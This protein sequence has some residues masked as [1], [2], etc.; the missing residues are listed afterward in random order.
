MC[1]VKLL[2]PP[3]RLASHM[4]DDCVLATCKE[5]DIRAP[6]H[7]TNFIV[8]E[9][10]FCRKCPH[11][12]FETTITPKHGRSNSDSSFL[13]PL[14]VPSEEGKYNSPIIAPPRPVGRSSTF[15]DADLLVSPHTDFDERAEKQREEEGRRHHVFERAIQRRRSLEEASG[16][17]GDRRREHAKRVERKRAPGIRWIDPRGGEG[18]KGKKDETRKKELVLPVPPPTS[19]KGTAR[20]NHNLTPVP[21]PQFPSPVLPSIQTAIQHKRAPT[22]E[23]LSESDFDFPSASTTADSWTT[24]TP[25][26][27]SNS[28]PTS[29]GGS[30]EEVAWSSNANDNADEGEVSAGKYLA[31]SQ[32]ICSTS[33]EVPVRCKPNPSQEPAEESESDTEGKTEDV[34]RT[35]P[36]EIPVPKGKAKPN[37]LG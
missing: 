27:N 4:G 33:D 24:T 36:I 31:S 18:I 1:I 25:S 16:S 20:I 21:V 23:E 37:L 6:G 19:D 35:A 26:S 17:D 22:P 28:G 34:P 9:L 30:G 10:V 15:D 32:A 5:T 12:P 8:S 29:A 3:C 11:I 14:D 7:L 13:S 2:R